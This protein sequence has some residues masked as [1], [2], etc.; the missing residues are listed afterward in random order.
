VWPFVEGSVNTAVVREEGAEENTVS[1]S[2][3]KFA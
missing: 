2:F 1:R 3:E